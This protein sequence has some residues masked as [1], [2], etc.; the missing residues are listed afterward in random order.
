MWVFRKIVHTAEVYAILQEAIVT[1]PVLFLSLPV[2]NRHDRVLD[3][4]DASC[5]VRV[6]ENTGMNFHAVA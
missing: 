2:S 6:Q 3:K 5:G 1:L 4:Q